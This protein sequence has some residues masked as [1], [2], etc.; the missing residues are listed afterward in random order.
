MG[1]K[2]D[3][4]TTW[5]I[6]CALPKVQPPT[7]ELDIPLGPLESLNLARLSQALSKQLK[8]PAQVVAV[9]TEKKNGWYS[10]VT[11]REV[12]H[13]GIN[14]VVN[15]FEERFP[16]DHYIQFVSHSDYAVGIVYRVIPL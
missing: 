2:K 1:M 5:P 7:K 13:C 14:E 12:E 16:S 6:D 15:S 8:K 4:F 3:P 11:H 10:D 9:L